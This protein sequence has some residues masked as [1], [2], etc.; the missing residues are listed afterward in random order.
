MRTARRRHRKSVGKAVE[1]LDMA[2]ELAVDSEQPWP[3]E[4][5]ITKVDVMQE[6]MA[7]AHKRHRRSIC[8]AVRQVEENERAPAGATDA[9]HEAV[10]QGSAAS[11][12]QS[13]AGA[14]SVVDARIQQ[15]VQ[16]AY[17]RYRAGAL[18]VDAT[19]WQD[20]A[21][22]DQ[23]GTG[24]EWQR[25][26]QQR[27]QDYQAYGPGPGCNGMSEH[28]EDGCAERGV[29]IVTPVSVDCWAEAPTDSGHQETWQNH[30]MG[31][32][33]DTWAQAST[34]SAHYSPEPEI[35]PQ[36][37]GV[38]SSRWIADSQCQNDCFSGVGAWNSCAVA[39]AVTRSRPPQ[40]WRYGSA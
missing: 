18:D 24:T 8:E 16:A 7:L 11:A 34:D 21:T 33:E 2:V 40:S 13:E 26:A 32:C 38:D 9:V 6:A 3:E 27:V 28:L 1:V 29:D 35:W 22:A 31:V 4:Q 36:H 39:A 10:R 5:V 14:L 20:T 19:H 17:T 30:T 23:C 25:C 12:A 15:A 37:V